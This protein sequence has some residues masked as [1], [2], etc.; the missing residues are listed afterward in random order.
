MN[1]LLISL[2]LYPYSYQNESFFIS[3]IILLFI[4]LI[5]FGFYKFIT[6]KMN[7]KIRTVFNRFLIFAGISFFVFFVVEMTIVLITEHQVNKQL[8][9]N[10]ATPDAPEGE[11]FL[12]T[13]V[14]TGKTMYLAGL[15]PDDQVRMNYVE[16][17]YK[18]LINNQKKEVVIPIIRD[19]KEVSINIKVPELDIPLT[20]VSFLF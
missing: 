5:A 4:S 14:V 15:K 11:L 16:D 19:K 12:I 10:Y 17:L 13:E 18:L 7:I 20:G 6:L 9:F 3:A 8:G 2:L 1:G